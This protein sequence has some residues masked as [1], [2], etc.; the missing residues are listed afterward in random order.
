MVHQMV[1]RSIIYMVLVVVFLASF[2]IHMPLDVQKTLFG[3][4]IIS[5][6]VYSDIVALYNGYL[7][8][9]NNTRIPY[10]DYPFPHPPL[11]M[12]LFTVVYTPISLLSVDLS[13]GFGLT[14]YY[15]L[16]S[17]LVFVSYMLSYIV[18]GGVVGDNKYSIV[19]LF[20]SFVIYLVYDW[21]IIVL[22]LLFASIMFFVRNHLFI[23]SIFSGLL[24]MY[25][26][27]FSVFVVALLFE[28]YV[29]GGNGFLM[30][31][32]LGVLWGALGYLLLLLTPYGVGSL[33]AYFKG[34]TC[35]NCIYLLAIHG[36]RSGQYVRA[37]S[38]GVVY[39]ASVFLL[40]SSSRGKSLISSV[41]SKG[42]IV[43]ATASILWLYMVPQVMIYLLPI[44][45][46][47]LVRRSEKITLLIADLLNSIIIL[48]WFKDIILRR[49]LSF[50]RIPVEQ[51]PWS[52]YSPIQ[53]IAQVRNI[54]LIIL[55][56]LIIYKN[57]TWRTGK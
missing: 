40:L 7:H 18:Y 36:A 51:N 28:W 43:L 57:Q 12:I 5:E 20:P 23:A 29:R 27:V 24:I 9:M 47:Y 56:I 8:G 35:M 3:S 2:I 46:L 10:V 55:I 42:L 34:L 33:T 44:Y 48:L 15:L 19:F 37:V 32:L 52:I 21:S 30:Y 4:I 39:A 31:G 17:M 25:D 50:T 22:F 14:L 26:P 6:P 13:S 11:R 53:W 38:L 54:L 1:R 49:M 45:I 41:Y 16:Y